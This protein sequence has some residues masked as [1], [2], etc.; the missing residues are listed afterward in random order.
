[1]RLGD[2][3][4]RRDVLDVAPGLVGKLLCCRDADGVVRRGRIAE[5]EAYRGEDDT[6][7][8]ARRGKT[9]RNSVMYGP[10]GT[11]YIYL[12]YGIH[13]L[14]NVVAAEAGTPEA[15]LIRGV[16]GYDGPGKLTKAMS[17]GRD[18]N[19]ACLITSDELWLEDDGTRFEYT[20]TPRVGIDYASDEDRARPW[21]F[22]AV[23]NI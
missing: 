19:G 23:C 20:T 11:A 17:I 6:A 22:V 18:L 12:C 10:G 3:F 1:M 15:A 4:Y 21:R 7:C 14:L 8:H 13:N 9:P 16:E 2:D 5:V